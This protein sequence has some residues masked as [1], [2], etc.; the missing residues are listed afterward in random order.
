[1]GSRL[2][3]KAD[4]QPLS[5]PGV[6]ILPHFYFLYILSQTPSSGASASF[7]ASP[8]IL[9][10][11]PYFVSLS[12]L[13]IIVIFSWTVSALLVLIPFVDS[14]QSPIFLEWKSD[15]M[16]LLCQWNLCGF[17]INGSLWYSNYVQTPYY[18][19]WAPKIGF[20]SFF[21]ASSHIIR[22]PLCWISQCSLNSIL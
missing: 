16:T 8:L 1:M 19:S 12:L 3:L 20:L 6:P 17:Q 11:V 10:L 7:G 13:F 14:P 2:E 9:V 22:F 15:F 5:H 18:A 21:Y 4:T